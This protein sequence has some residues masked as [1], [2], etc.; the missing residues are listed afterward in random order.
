MEDTKKVPEKSREGL[1]KLVSKLT[2]EE[3]KEHIDIFMD[4]LTA[5]GSLVTLHGKD[6]K[7]EA[8]TKLDITAEDKINLMK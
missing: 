8:E 2:L 5:A 4:T 1:M 6:T 3:A 7:T